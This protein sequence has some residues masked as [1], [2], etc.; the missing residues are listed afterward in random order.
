MLRLERTMSLQIFTSSV[1]LNRSATCPSTSLE[2]EECAFTV[3]M[4]I[5]LTD[6]KIPDYLLENAATKEIQDWYQEPT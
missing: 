4:E 1:T 5:T 2:N 3:F 6:R